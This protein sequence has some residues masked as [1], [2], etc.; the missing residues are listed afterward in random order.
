MWIRTLVRSCGS[1]K[2]YPPCFLKGPDFRASYSDYFHFWWLKASWWMSGR[3]V[4]PVLDS[5]VYW[6]A[7]LR[8]PTASSQGHVWWQRPSFLLKLLRVSREK[9]NDSVLQ[10]VQCY[11]NIATVINLDKLFIRPWSKVFPAVSVD[12]Y[13]FPGLNLKTCEILPFERPPICLSHHP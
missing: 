3:N 9:K 7:D 5:V 13:W 4:S 1:Q 6:P 10:N 11:I 12:Q 2:M 8:Q